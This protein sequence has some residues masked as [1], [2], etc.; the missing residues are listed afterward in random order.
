M[1]KIVTVHGAFSKDGTKKEWRELISPLKREYDWLDF[2][3]GWVGPITTRRRSRAAGEDL[4]KEVEKDDS[5]IA[6]S[7]GGLVVWEALEA[8]MECNKVILIQPALSKDISFNGN[9]ERIYITYNRKDHI[10][11]LSRLWSM[12][13]RYVLNHKWGALGKYGYQG[14]DRRVKN[15]DQEV[16]CGSLGHFQWRSKH[17]DCWSNIVY[18]LVNS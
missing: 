8:G 16:E 2:K 15:I 11:H 1:A 18:D 10:V 4:A 12:P 14:D 13:F 17:M 3:Y 5:I 6:F 7:N 9:A